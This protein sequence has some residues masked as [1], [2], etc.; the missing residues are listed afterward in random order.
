MKLYDYVRSTAAY[1]VRIALNLKGVDYESIPVSL[2]DGDQNSVEY[3]EVNSAGL[4]PSLETQGDII[5]Q[6]LAIIEY[7]DELYPEL[8]L[9][10][11]HPIKRAQC[12]A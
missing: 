3:L 9:L 2:L 10:P 11:E 1:R 7:L 4:V 5:T 6:S 12:R 8:P